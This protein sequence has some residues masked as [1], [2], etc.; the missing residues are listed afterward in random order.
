MF[1]FL[2]KIKFSFLA[3]KKGS[4]PSNADFQIFSFVVP[5]WPPLWLSR[6]DVWQGHHLPD[7]PRYTQVEVGNTQVQAC[8]LLQLR[9]VHTQVQGRIQEVRQKQHLLQVRQVYIQ[10]QGRI[11]EV[12]KKQHLL[13]GRTQVQGHIQEVRQKLY[14][15]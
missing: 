1:L 4:F 15:L 12:R 10:V 11:Q 14:L 9:Q 7:V 5:L 6:N 8:S 13:R 3:S 2:F